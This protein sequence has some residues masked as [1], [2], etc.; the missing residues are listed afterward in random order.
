MQINQTSIKSGII[1][2]VKK[3]L[4]LQD[5]QHTAKHLAHKHTSYRGLFVVMAVFGL[6]LFF[7]A[8]TVGADSYVVNARVAAPIPTI[9]A[10]ITSPLSQTT[11]N[12]PNIII[13]GTCPIISP[14]IIVVL[15]KGVNVL[16]SASCTILGQFSGTFSLTEGINTIVPKIVTITN[17][18][19]PDGPAA[20]ITYKQPVI[21]PA[22]ATKSVASSSQT[23]GVTIP[24][25]NELLVKTESPFL[26]FKQDQSFVWK[27]NIAGGQSP[28]TVLV[29]W[30]DGNK[31]TYAANS[32]G[33]QV[34]EHI[35]KQNKNMLVR[36]SVR[37]ASG[38]EVYTTVAG[39]TIRQQSTPLVSGISQV[40]ASN[41]LP[42]AKLWII[43][44]LTVVMIFS[45]WLGARGHNS[46]VYVNS[47]KKAPRIKK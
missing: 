6:S 19:G 11:V 47:K 18:F 3:V 26:I 40:A 1:T 36:V 12:S 2:E 41:S 23:T 16:G 34:L 13:S 38:K 20:N 30:G 43:Y 21:E 37:D 7:V 35:Y 28:Y 42:I 31:S 33:D 9:A 44:S 29:D 45:F 24:P 15:Y 25:S 39:V 17:D 8:K 10:N 22:P 32:A 46:T 4:K 5:H 14:A 27:I